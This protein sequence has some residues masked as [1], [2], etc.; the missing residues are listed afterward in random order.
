MAKIN[1]F[2]RKWWCCLIRSSVDQYPKLDFY[3]SCSLNQQ[4]ADRH[5]DPLGHISYRLSYPVDVKYITVNS[6]HLFVCL[7]VC[8]FDGV[9][10]HFQQY[11]SYIVEVS[12]IDQGNRRARRKPPT[13]R[14]Q[15]NKWTLFTV[16]YFTSTGYDKHSKLIKYYMLYIIIVTSEWLFVV[17]QF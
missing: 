8:L 13:C 6:V 7:F 2:N 14:K 15:T 10:R 16:I 17:L 1:Y 5:V 11:F 12:F 4:L 9:K 3:N